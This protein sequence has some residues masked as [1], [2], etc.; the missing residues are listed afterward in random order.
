MC[1]AVDFIQL[2]YTA[3]LR[4]FRQRSRHMIHTTEDWERLTNC[5]PK[6]FYTFSTNY[7]LTYLLTY[8]LILSLT[9]ATLN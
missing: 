8:L 5:K 6:H 2:L 3:S 4:H 9:H 7:L 1:I